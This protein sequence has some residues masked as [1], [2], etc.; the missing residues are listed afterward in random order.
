MKFQR[1]SGIVC[2]HS[3]PVHPGPHGNLCS[4]RSK[5]VPDSRVLSQV[6][7]Q[8]CIYRLG[9]TVVYKGG[10]GP[11]VSTQIAC[12]S[13]IA[14]GRMWC[15]ECDTCTG[16]TLVKIKL[17]AIQRFKAFP[18]TGSAFLEVIEVDNVQEISPTALIR[19]GTSMNYFWS[20]SCLSR[21]PYRILLRPTVIDEA[22]L[23]FNPFAAP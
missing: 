21:N 18:L 9:P 1:T 13:Q 19:S 11:V 14:W 5:N 15:E 12:N 3:G 4:L 16:A 8:N 7:S 6:F 2:Y 23:K 10:C 17:H 20:S 22:Y